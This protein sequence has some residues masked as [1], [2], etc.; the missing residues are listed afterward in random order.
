VSATP[1]GLRPEV[2]AFATTLLEGRDRAR[3]A[4]TRPRSDHT[5][6]AALATIRDFA[7][8]LSSRGKLDWALVDVHDIEA[9]LAAAPAGRARRLT[10]LRQ[11]FRAAR[12]HKT[13]LIDPPEA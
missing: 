2:A 9:F 13:V 8:C 10:V 7:S 11:F 6:D 4:G 5:I 1:A 12:A 3:R